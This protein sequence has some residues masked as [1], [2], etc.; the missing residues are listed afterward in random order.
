MSE[1]LPRPTLVLDTR[2]A[3][4][5]EALFTL[6]VERKTLYTGDLGIAGQEMRFAVEMKWTLGDLVSSLSTDRERFQR[7]VWRLRGCDFRR[8]LLV[9]SPAAVEAGQYRSRM[10]PL[11]VLHSLYAI[12]ARGVPVVWASTE[13]SAA[14][15]VERWAQWFARE[16]RR[17]VKV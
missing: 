11:A 10:N 6:P 13:K 7:E 4:G 14:E 9:G 8:L 1:E 2:E 17:G 12:E 16:M 15:L 5:R 3:P